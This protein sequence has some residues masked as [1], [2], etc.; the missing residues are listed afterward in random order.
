MHEGEIVTCFLLPSD[1]E[2]SESIQP[3]RA[4][5]HYPSLRLV[6]FHHVVQIFAFVPD[7]RNVPS[8]DDS[9]FYLGKI[10]SLVQ[11]Q[12]LRMIGRWRRSFDDD[13]IERVH[14]GLHVMDID[15]LR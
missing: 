5:F 14:R 15:W 2:L 10:V 9:T 1:E 7:V 4:P 6:A 12:V 11:T 13:A 3:G 8:L